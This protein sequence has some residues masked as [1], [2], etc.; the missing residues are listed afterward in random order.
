MIAKSRGN[1]RRAAVIG[2]GRDIDIG[3]LFDKTQRE[4]PDGTLRQRADF[5]FMRIY[6]NVI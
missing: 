1:R 4:I 2:D 5:D 6:L 3:T